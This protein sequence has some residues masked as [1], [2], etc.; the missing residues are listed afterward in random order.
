MATRKAI[1]PEVRNFSHPV[2]DSLFI[3]AVERRDATAVRSYLHTGGLSSAAIAVAFRRAAEIGTVEVVKEFLTS[4]LIDPAGFD[5]LALTVA[6]GAGQTDVVRALLADPRVDPSVNDNRSLEIAIE[7]GHVEVVRMLMADPRVDPRVPEW[8]P[9]ISI[10]EAPANRVELL[11]IFLADRRVD[12]SQGNNWMENMLKVGQ[13]TPGLSAERKD[14]IEQMLGLLRTGSRSLRVATMGQQ[15][16]RKKT[17][18]VK[19]IR[20]RRGTRAGRR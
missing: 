14:E 7:N 5:G 9:F 2:A 16:G 13:Q 8:R 12:P 1:P 20:K 18:R 3:D 19:K 11:K 17:R 6:A 15:G 10:L 4:G